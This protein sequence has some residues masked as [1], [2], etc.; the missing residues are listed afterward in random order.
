[1][2]FSASSFQFHVYTSLLGDICA[3]FFF[4]FS[5]YSIRKVLRFLV[6][7]FLLPSPRTIPR[8]GILAAMIHVETQVAGTVWLVALVWPIPLFSFHFSQ[9]RRGQGGMIA[10]R[11]SDSG[12]YER[13]RCC[14]CDSSLLHGTD[15]FI[16]LIIPF[17]FS[18]RGVSCC[19]SGLCRWHVWSNVQ[20]VFTLGHVFFV[21]SSVHC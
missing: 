14:V 16:S 13:R 1:M 11:L 5:F 20:F 15:I 17:L 2:S 12:I 9:K 3:R 7:S 8:L 21:H 6:T 19:S 10:S 18:V 4:H